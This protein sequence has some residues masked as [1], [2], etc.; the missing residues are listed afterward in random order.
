MLLLPSL[1][2]SLVIDSTSNRSSLQGA[3]QFSFVERGLME[4]GELWK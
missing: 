2:F 4:L 1:P 3:I